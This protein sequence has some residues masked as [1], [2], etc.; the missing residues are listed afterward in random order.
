MIARMHATTSPNGRMLFDEEF[1]G[2]ALDTSKWQPNW[3]GA[4]DA[5]ITKPINNAEASCYDPKQVSVSGGFLH[6]DAAARSCT[7]NNHVTYKYASGLVNTLGRFTFTYGHLEARVWVGSGSGPV[8]N[9]PAFWA[10][11]TGTWP[12]TGENDVFEGLN[13]RD[14][15]HF[16]SVSGGPGHC[17]PAANP[18]GWH[19]FAADWAPGRV[20]YVYDGQVVGA[21]TQ[22][23]TD[24]P[25]Y[26]IL[27][28]GV[29]GWGGAVQAPAT[30]LVDYVR[31]WGA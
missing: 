17:A 31:V 7:A 28:L 19:V 26:L 29:G 8:T 10:A 9:W 11:G 20:T 22:G 25:M 16:H 12:V 6:L 14:C 18:S 5:A 1:D 24:T 3:L 23:I 15:Y 27:N 13:G 2:G 4:N 30:M 21:I